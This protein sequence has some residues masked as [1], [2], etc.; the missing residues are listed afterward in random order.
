MQALVAMSSSSEEDEPKKDVWE[1]HQSS[2]ESEAATGAVSTRKLTRF[3]AAQ[4]AFLNAYYNQGLTGTGKKYRSFIK[5]AAFDAGM[6]TTQVK[7]G[8]YVT[9]CHSVS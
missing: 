7:V 3:T 6:T 5:R 2:S 4:I 9:V 8:W 1:S